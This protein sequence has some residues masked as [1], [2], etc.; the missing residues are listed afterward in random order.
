MRLTFGW[1]IVFA[2]TVFTTGSIK[3]VLYKTCWNVRPDGMPKTLR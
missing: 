3:V 2:L 1:K